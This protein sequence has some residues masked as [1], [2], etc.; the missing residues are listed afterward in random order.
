M[1]DRDDPAKPAGPTHVPAGGAPEVDIGDLAERV[2][3]LMAVDLRSELARGVPRP[4]A[5]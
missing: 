5:E 3:R 1:A 4:R 2:Y